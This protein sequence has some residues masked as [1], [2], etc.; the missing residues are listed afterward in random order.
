MFA[1]L[2]AVAAAPVGAADNSS[3]NFGD[4]SIEQ[5]M[6]ESVSSV[7]KKET[8]LFDSAAAVAVVSQEDI[9][10]LGITS[11]PEA[12]RLVPGLDVARISA[13]EWAVSARGFNSEFANKLLVLVDGRAVYTPA[14]GGVF[15]NAQDVV[16]EDL[17]RIEVIR[18]PG[19]T[20]WGTNAVNGV[21]NLTTKSAKETQG[22]LLSTAV[23]T[24]DRPAATVRYGGQLAPNFYYRAYV[25]CADR[26]DVWRRTLRA[27]AGDGHLAA[28][29]Q[30]HDPAH[31]RATRLNPRGR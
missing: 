1:L 18:G 22:V 9:R 14:S 6:N 15:W 31:A 19:A 23:G 13:N 20:L 17:D 10:R 4:L 12:L 25:K 27:L 24:E 21:I 26:R 28:G 11:I 29:R 7:S 30:L 3:R 2:G 5:L 8:R 16:L